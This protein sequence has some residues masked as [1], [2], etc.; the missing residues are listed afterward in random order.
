MSGNLAE[1]GPL[2]KFVPVPGGSFVAAFG[3]SA[4]GGG[5]DDEFLGLTPPAFLALNITGSTISGNTALGLGPSSFGAFGGGLDTNSAVAQVT[6]STVSG[7]Q[8]IGGPGGGW[9]PVGRACS[10]PVVH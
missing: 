6:N 2:I 1:S 4:L 5:I 9:T 7:N 10:R 8:A 3:S